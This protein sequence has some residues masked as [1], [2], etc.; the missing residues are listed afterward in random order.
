L[1]V[2]TVPARSPPR[3]LLVLCLQM[4]K[5]QRDMYTHSNHYQKCTTIWILW[6]A[7]EAMYLH[8]VYTNIIKIS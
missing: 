7:I 4:C 2:S 5:K 8:H 3:R 1:D 6:Y